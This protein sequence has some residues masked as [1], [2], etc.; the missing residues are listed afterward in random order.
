MKRKYPVKMGLV[1][2][3]CLSFMLGN[4]SAG[5]VFAQMNG[6]NADP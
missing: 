1:V 3:L 6:G 2:L 4:F 5:G